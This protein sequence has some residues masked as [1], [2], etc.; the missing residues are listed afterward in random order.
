MRGGDLPR[1]PCGV[2]W[3]HG[4]DLAANFLLIPP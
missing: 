1:T 2:F 3:A 4:K